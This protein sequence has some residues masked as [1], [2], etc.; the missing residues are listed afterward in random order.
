[1]QSLLIEDEDYENST[2]REMSDRSSERVNKND[3][4]LLTCNYLFITYYMLEKNQA[5]KLKYTKVVF[6]NSV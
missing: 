6:N 1:M 5:T 4:W 2:S 3:I